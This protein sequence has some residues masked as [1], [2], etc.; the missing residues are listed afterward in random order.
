MGFEQVRYEAHWWNEPILGQTQAKR[1][2]FVP[3]LY[4]K[5]F[6]RSDGKIRVVDLEEEREYV[7][8]LSNVA[9]ETRYYDVTVEGQHYSAEDWLAELEGDAASVLRLLLVDP[10]AI[11]R[12]TDEQEN[13]LSRFVAALSIRTPFR[14]QEL[15]DT[16][17]TVFSQIE[18]NLQGQ[19]VHKF[20]KAQGQELYEEWQ[21]KPFHERIGEQEP[22][23]A[24]STTN[25]LLSEVQG[26]AN[27]LQAAP[28]RLGEVPGQTRLYTSDNP[29]S[30]YLR[31][32]RSWWDGAAFSSFDY[33][34]PLSPGLL[35][36]IERRPDLDDSDSAVSARGGR[37]KKDFSIWEI[38]MARHIISRDASRYLYGDGLVVPKQCAVSCLNRIESAMREFA[39]KY[40]GYGAKPPSG[41]GFPHPGRS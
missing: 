19:F 24:A 29:V 12:L 8:S 13:S 10:G 16:L 18:E 2:H 22:T 15:N 28:W 17:N 21:A 1:Q 37:R 11:A 32:V 23:Q 7:S 9:V 6:T 39:A 3:R 30:R 33:F 20:G 26:F 25:F 40:L 38:S 5:P 27:L 35:L 14:R 36:K 34:L 41:V 31:P 4:L